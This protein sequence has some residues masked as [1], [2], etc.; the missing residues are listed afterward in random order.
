MME[1]F[2]FIRPL[3][4]LAA[5]PSIALWWA[6][7]RRSDSTETWRRIIA[8]HLLP[9]L[10]GQNK[11]ARFSQ[12]VHF[13]GLG[14]LAGGLAIAGPTWRRQPSPFV[15]DTA[16][17]VI[18][19]KV[20]PSMLTEDVQ[21]TRLARSV[22]KI[23]DLLIE[24]GAGKTALIAYAGSAHVVMPATT[25]AAIIELFA[26][27]LDPKIMPTEGADSA[28]GM[29]L[30]DRV[31]HDA[32]GGSILWITDEIAGAEQTALTQWRDKSSTPVHVLAPLPDG[33]ALD[34]LQSA[35]G[36][37]NARVIELTPDASDV[38]AIVS[39]AKYSR[40]TAGGESTHWE[41]SGYWLTPLLAIGALFFFRRGW[42]APTA[43]IQT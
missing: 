16:A 8:P 11:A 25:D 22:E 34:K 40:T 19:V 35:A 43:S 7:F 3:W 37:V 29:H 24:R 6:L 30:A 31:L 32:G 2:H 42:M 38:H 20:T 4:L 21:P 13:I 26:G 17:L 14:W 41:E 28:A 33:T 36:V 12:A 15:D 23:H 18:V 39:A 10:I 5:I 9:H 1:D 27:S